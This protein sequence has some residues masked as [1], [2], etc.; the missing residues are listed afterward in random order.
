LPGSRGYISGRHGR[1]KVRKEFAAGI[2]LVLIL[3]ISFGGCKKSQHAKP[4]NLPEQIK[5]KLPSGEVVTAYRMAQKPQT[6]PSGTRI[7]VSGQVRKESDDIGSVQL[8]LETEVGSKYILLN[9]PF[10]YR[11]EKNALGKSA[12]IKGVT[13]AKTSFKG[14]PAIYIEDIIEIR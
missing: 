11:L 6:P 2:L 13:I 5:V 4:Q 8:V 12:K 3:G 9:P 10:M 14:Y 7:I 1:K